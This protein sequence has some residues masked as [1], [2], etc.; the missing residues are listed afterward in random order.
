VLLT[1]I[2]LMVMVVSRQ[3]DVPVLVPDQLWL[4]C[5]ISSCRG[6]DK[7]VEHDS[8]DTAAATRPNGCCRS[9]RRPAVRDAPG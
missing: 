1:D 6:V 4:E 3:A 7:T 9:Q 8:M 2:V 5:P